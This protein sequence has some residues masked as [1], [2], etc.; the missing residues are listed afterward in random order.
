MQAD[1][2]NDSTFWL[3]LND[4]EQ[5]I[6]LDNPMVTDQ[7]LVIAAAAGRDNLPQFYTAQIICKMYKIKDE[8]Y[9]MVEDMVEKNLC[10]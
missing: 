2:K 4:F 8:M 7:T 6:M 9:A 10:L 3:E 1:F 5:S